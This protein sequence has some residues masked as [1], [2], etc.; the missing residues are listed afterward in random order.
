MSDNN[1]YYQEIMTMNKSYD[2]TFNALYK[3][4]TYKEDEIN[5]IF[6]DIKTNLIEKEAFS[7]SQM[8]KIVANIARHRNK[9]FKSYWTIFKKIYNQYQPISINKIDSVFDYFMNKEY[10]II[11]NKSNKQYFEQFE[12]EKYSLEVHEPGTIY[13]A[14]MDDDKISFI[15]FINCIG[16]DK[17]KMLQSGFY[18]DSDKGYSLLELCCYHGSVD[19]FKLLR[20]EF[21]SQITDKCLAFAFLSESKEIMSECLKVADPVT[22]GDVN[23]VIT[24]LPND[25]CMEYAL[26][27]HNIDLVT[28][29][30]DECH[31]E[32]D[33]LLCG[34]YHNLQAFSAY[35]DREKKIDECFAFSPLFNIPSLCEYLLSQGA[36]IKY[37][38][39]TTQS[40]LYYS[41]ISDNKITAEFLISHGVPLYS[42]ALIKPPLCIAAEYDSSGVVDI[43]LSH[44]P[45]KNVPYHDFEQP[46]HIAADNNCVETVKVLLSHHVPINARGQNRMFTPLHCA[47]RKNCVEM[48]EYLISQKAIIDAQDRDKQTPLFLAAWNDNAE[49]LETL[50]S[51]GANVNI[52]NNKGATPIHVGAT[53][54]C[55]RVG[56]ILLSHGANVNAK[57][58]EGSTPLHYAATFGNEKMVKYFLEHGAKKNAVDSSRKMPYQ[59]AFDPELKKLLT[60]RSSKC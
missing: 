3:L 46:I 35:L 21:N 13:R 58:D 17:D 19:C 16:F 55:K 52:R 49:V 25:N 24:K 39:I 59:L 51:H 23:S 5:K 50:I 36:N 44:D 6:E 1:H 20:T 41:A 8:C 28:Y 31:M 57:D 32:L 4:K 15:T 60:P 12:T 48:A 26:I 14:I 7:P 33:L 43:L 30:I 47:A 34:K 10:G 42:K 29:L 9:Y 54:L 37:E 53:R 56:C 40:A 18:P 22:Y 27:S 38:P 2:D 11:F 45:H